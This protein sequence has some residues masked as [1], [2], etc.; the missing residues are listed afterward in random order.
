MNTRTKSA[1]LIAGTLIVGVLIGALATARVTDQRLDRMRDLRSRDGFAETVL[2]AI[3]PTSPEQEKQIKAILSESHER[4]G[5]LRREWR[6]SLR[7][8]GDTMRKALTEILTPAQIEAL[9]GWMERRQRG[10]RRGAE[11]ERRHRRPPDSLDRRR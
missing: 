7:A 10:P 2:Q 3:E 9:D 1:L 4:M 11:G 8:E 6:V 5:D